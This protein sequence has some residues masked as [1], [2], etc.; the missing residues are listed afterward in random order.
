MHAVSK[1]FPQACSAYDL[2]GCCTNSAAEKCALT[3]RYHLTEQASRQQM[4]GCT[5]GAERDFYLLDHQAGNPA[6]RAAG[7]AA[8]ASAY[9]TE[10]SDFP[11]TRI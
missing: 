4:Y 10:H 5:S 2:G 11:V 6:Y 9:G 3:F 8:A 1:Q 7:C